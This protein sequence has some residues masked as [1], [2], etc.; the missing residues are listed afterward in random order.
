MH[1]KGPV[2]NP[3][4]YCGIALLSTAWGQGIW[5]VLARHAMQFLVPKVVSPSQ[6]GNRPGRSTEDLIF[7]MSYVAV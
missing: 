6:C 1:K 2:N 7:V 4:N 3:K 5:Q